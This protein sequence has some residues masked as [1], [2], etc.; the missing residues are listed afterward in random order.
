MC[1]EGL[2]RVVIE[3]NNVGVPV[4][5]SRRGG[6]PELIVEGETGWLVEPGN[7]ASLAERI[8]AALDDPER[9]HRMGELARKLLREQ[10]EP[11]KITSDV[12]TVYQAAISGHSLP[13]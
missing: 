12:L 9:L 10:F 13:R 8:I 4:V 7:P 5:A 6:I 11:D 3:A 1:F 2:G